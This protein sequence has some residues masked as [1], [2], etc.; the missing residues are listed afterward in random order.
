MSDRLRRGGKI[1]YQIVCRKAFSSVLIW[2][3]LG[4]HTNS[5]SG[6]GGVMAAPAMTIVGGKVV[7]EAE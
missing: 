1:P 3:S 7:Y 2:A 5:P 4:R 6:K